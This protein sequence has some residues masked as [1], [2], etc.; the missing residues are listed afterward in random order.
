M[1]EVCLS[2][3]PTLRIIGT[4]NGPQIDTLAIP[5]P[6]TIPTSAQDMVAVIPGPLGGPPSDQFANLN[7]KFGSAGNG[8]KTSKYHK[9]ENIIGGNGH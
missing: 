2:L 4:Q 8:K 1:P 6:V 5:E 9:K 3:Y 7:E